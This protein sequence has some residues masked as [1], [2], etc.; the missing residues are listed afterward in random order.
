M[1]T[2][3][4]VTTSSQDHHDRENNTR[5]VDNIGSIITMLISDQVMLFVLNALD[6]LHVWVVLCEHNWINMIA[7]QQYM[8]PGTSDDT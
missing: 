8:A 4:V 3:Q 7:C 1:T 6:K 2:S 5:Q